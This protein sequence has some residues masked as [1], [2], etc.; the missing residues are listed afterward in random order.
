VANGHTNKALRMLD[1]VHLRRTDG[2]VRLVNPVVNTLD[3]ATP[4]VAHFASALLSNLPPHL[5]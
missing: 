5:P 3:A 1:V 4:D 2:L